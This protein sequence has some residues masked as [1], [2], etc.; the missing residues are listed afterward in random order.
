MENYVI[1]SNIGTIPTLKYI[2]YIRPDQFFFNRI[3]SNHALQ[4]LWNQ[5][6]PLIISIN[7]IQ[8]LVEYA[9]A[10]GNQILINTILLTDFVL[11]AQ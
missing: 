8:S 11:R 3:F 2:I 6:I 7:L 5:T 1:L 9:M 4:L 10:S